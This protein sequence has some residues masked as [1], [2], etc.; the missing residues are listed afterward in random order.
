MSSFGQF[1]D[2][3]WTLVLPLLVILATA[4]LLYLLGYPDTAWVVSVPG[5]LITYL[6]VLVYIMFFDSRQR[7][8]G[9]TFLQ[10]AAR[11]FFLRL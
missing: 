6:V 5:T 4:P 8:P 10:R 9:L 2:R 11:L 7:W 1:V 3:C